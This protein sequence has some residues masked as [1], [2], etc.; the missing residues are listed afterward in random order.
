MTN[1]YCLFTIDFN[2]NITFRLLDDY[3]NIRIEEFR[4]NIEN[5]IRDNNRILKDIFDILTQSI[6]SIKLTTLSNELKNKTELII[7][8]D[9]LLNLLPFEALYD[10][11]KYLIETKT[12]SYIS[13]AKEFVRGLKREKVNNKNDIVAFGDANFDMKFDSG[14]RG[15]PLLLKE[16][17]SNLPATKNEIEAISKIYPNAKIYTNDK[18]SVENLLNIKNPKILHLATHGFY[19][20]DE[21]THPL[22]KS[23]LA[24][25]GASRASKVGDTRGII[26]ALKISTMDL[27]DTDLVVLSACESGLGDINSSDGVMN[28]S[29]AFIQAGAKSVII[30]LWKINDEATSILIQDFYDNISKGKSYK[31]A[32]REAKLKMI[33]KNPFYWSSL[34]ISGV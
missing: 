4:Y 21:D 11:E 23:G 8:P 7:S 30:S 19:L 13:S 32:L 16:E 12:I 6:D 25:S 2:N 28:L 15:V 10:G 18:A 3:L 17:F 22:E 31:E 5:N 26:T 14:S 20:K 24:F 9:G 1:K 34:I 27:N 33:D 29:S